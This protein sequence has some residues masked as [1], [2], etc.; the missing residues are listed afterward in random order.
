MPYKDPAVKAARRREYDRARRNETSQA[1]RNRR[2]AHSPAFVGVDGEGGDIDGRHE[3]LLLRAGNR[4][5]ETGFPL[6]SLE[7]LEFLATL[8]VGVEY[9]SYFFT[10]DVTMILRDLPQSVIQ[11][12]LDRE[13]RTDHVEGYV[14]RVRYGTYLMDW[15]PGKEFRIKKVGYHQENPW[16]V[17]SDA[18][19]FF[20]SAFVDALEAW[21]IGTPELRARIAASKAKRSSFGKITPLTRLYNKKECDLLAELME[22][23]RRVVGEVGPYPKQ[24]QGPGNLAVAWLRQHK[25]PQ[26]HNVPYECMGFARDAYYGGRFEVTG[27]GI[28]RRKIFQYDINSA[29]P[30]VIRNLPCLVHGTWKH[31]TNVRS[32]PRAP[33]YVAKVEFSHPG[34]RFLGTLP[35]RSE[36]GNI[37]YPQRGSGIYWSMELAAAKRAGCV[38]RVSEAWEYTT[39]CDCKPIGWVDDIYQLRLKIGKTNKGMVLKLGLNSLYGKFA[40]SVGTPRWANPIWAGIITASTRAQIIDACREIPEENV[41]MI[42][43]DGIFTDQPLNKLPISRQLGDWELT[44][45]DWMFI[46]QPGLYMLPLEK[47]KTRGVPRVK[48]IE[49]A[50][51]IRKGWATQT[52]HTGGFHITIPLHRFRAARQALHENNWRGAGEWYSQFRLVGFQWSTKRSTI[53]G[54]W[55][56]VSPDRS[57]PEDLP[58]WRPEIIEEGGATVPYGKSIGIWERGRIWED[59]QPEEAD[60][61]M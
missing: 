12:L 50:R 26:E 14:R 16:I 57:F 25:V 47:P 7:C 8:P 37:S 3:Y 42:A 30:A 52:S 34:R 51:Q 19:S 46:I 44:E 59:D 10:Y 33:I 18:G 48:I 36:K 43:T 31:R 55:D 35:I 61:L 53:S 23:F 4:V 2:H 27:I 39:T 17:I 32:L 24:W 45:H 29:Y 60:V 6:S 9:T 13:S 5:L 1:Q 11:S 49:Y 20:Q 21:G 54:H 15:L 41:L 58:A 22:E 40:Q 38:L 28:F 56:Q